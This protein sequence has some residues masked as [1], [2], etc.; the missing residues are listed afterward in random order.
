M[1]LVIKNLN[2]TYKNGV[3][4]IDNLDLEIGA[5]MF[6]LLGPNGAGKSSLMRTIATLQKPDSGTIHFGDINILEQQSEFR[7]LL[8]YL[9]QD[10]GVYPN[11]SAVDLLDYFARLK[12]ISKATERKEIVTKVLEVT[13]LYEVRRKSVSGYSGGMKQRFGIAQLLLNDPKLI[14]VDE[15]TAGLDPAERHRFL[16]V[17]REIG[18]NNTVIF[19]TH[20]VDDV[21][22]LCH[23]MAILNGGNLLERSTPK[24]AEQKLEGK[25]WTRETTRE[26]AEELN[27]ELMIL[28]GKYNQDNKLNIRV[29]SEDSLTEAGFVSVQPSLEDVYFVAL[30]N[31]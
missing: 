21:N 29:Y 9:P 25:I 15:P 31:G 7:K 6:G 30:K 11:M 14:I 19:S 27:K 2:K 23:E 1:K 8:G 5:G 3:K 26:V 16:N 18:N 24:Q 13:N 17:L 20:I 22:E 28:S 12:G 4:A 10:F